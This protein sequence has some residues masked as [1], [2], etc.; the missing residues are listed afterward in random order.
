MIC[1]ALYMGTL[2][3]DACSCGNQSGSVTVSQSS[4]NMVQRMLF[5]SSKGQHRSDCM[6]GM[7]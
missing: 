5:H 7:H 4:V 3:T 2:R 1:W 6:Y